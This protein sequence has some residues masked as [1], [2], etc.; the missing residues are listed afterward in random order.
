MSTLI[1]NENCW[2]GFATAMPAS[3]ELLPTEAEVAAATELTDFVISLNASET[4]NVVPIPSLKS[5]FEKSIPGTVTGTFTASMYRDSVSADDTAWTKLP[6]DATGVFYIAR[7]KAGVPAAA[8]IIE[9]WPI[10]VSART[11]DQL[12]S[13]TAQT[14]A[15]TCSLPE[16]PNTAAAVSV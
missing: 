6:M 1:P 2:I 10:R 15:L 7:F 14:F 3:A 11:P 8:D 12:T 5:R 4:G 13:N 16:V 9:V